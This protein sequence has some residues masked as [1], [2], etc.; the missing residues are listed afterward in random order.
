MKIN[1]TTFSGNVID[2]LDPDIDTLFLTDIVEHLS[3]VYRHS[4]G[5]PISVAQHSVVVSHHP[6]VTRSRDT[7]LEALLHDAAEFLLGDVPTPLKPHVSI[8]GHPYD[9]I[10]RQFLDSVYDAHRYA[11][12]NPI[13]LFRGEKSPAVA[14]ADRECGEIERAIYITGQDPAE[15]SDWDQGIDLLTK[16][17]PTHEVRHAFL[18]RWASFARDVK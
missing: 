6:L 3:R 12:D 17:L 4:G 5:S 1:L 13:A 7:I 11:F 15:I 18:R 2:I 16:P 8:A 10:E 14:H 9:V